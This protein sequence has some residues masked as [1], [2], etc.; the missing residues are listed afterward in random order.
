MSIRS[1]PVPALDPKRTRG[2]EVRVV[3]RAFYLRCLVG[4]SRGVHTEECCQTYQIVF[5]DARKPEAFALS[6]EHRDAH[7]ASLRGFD[8][9][10]QL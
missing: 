3:G 10:G 9:G 7:A 8:D 6:E 5:S 1:I 2:Y 4:V